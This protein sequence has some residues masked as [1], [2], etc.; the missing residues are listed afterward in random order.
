M[1]FK[2]FIL[3]TSLLAANIPM[4][5]AQDT[6]TE[7]QQLRLSL[8]EA[9]DYAVRHNYA[10]QNA[11]LDQK[12]A[13]AAKW[14]A[15]SSMLPQGSVNFAYQNML[16]YEIEFGNTGMKL[17][18]NPNGQL[19]ARAALALSGAQVVGAVLSNISL[20]M[21][22]IK[23]RQ[24]I[25][26]SEANVKNIY[27]SILVM[28]E[29]MS[30]L[31]SS[32]A[33]LQRLKKS[34]DDAVAAGA[35]EQVDA[36]K[37]AV[38]VGTLRN[39]I[40]SNKRAL[41]MLQNSLLLQLGAD[42]GISITLTTPL[43]EILSIDGAHQTLRK[44]FDITR[45]FDYQTLVQSEAA[46]KKQLTLAYM[47]YLPTLTAYY[48]YSRLTY[49]G[50]DEGF[51]MNPPHMIGATLSWN[52]FTSGSRWKKVEAA[53]LEHEKTLNSMR[54]AED[55]LK[56]QYKQAS[57]DLVNALETYDIQKENIDVSQRVFANIA[58]KYKYGRSSSLDV[59]QA[60]SNLITA[61]SS[62][63]QAVVSVVNAQVVLETLLSENQ[64]EEK[65]Q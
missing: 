57:F 60:S 28:Q 47:D 12:K 31:D 1:K 7:P 11:T 25:Q 44:S 4:L 34:T 37:L 38:Q 16:G 46:S 42:P 8:R 41:Q 26:A 2:I 21:S 6:P 58:E 40:H 55:A 27:T 18:M 29:T 35:S 54:Q 32:L 14:Q 33:N 65:N 30:L 64:Y 50:K 62:Y 51:N 20:K 43:N 39:S 61:Q 10:L 24:T 49:F 9:Q 45:N 36:D 53:K 5:A 59:T 52:L 19:T 17:A 56:V 48:Q 63:I 3:T 13:E 23:H 15:V 22:D